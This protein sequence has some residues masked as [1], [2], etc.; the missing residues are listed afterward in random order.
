MSFVPFQRVTRFHHA[1]GRRGTFS[2]RV[3][4]S[5]PCTTA[6]H[7]TI[8]GISALDR[9]EGRTG[10][11]WGDAPT[12]YRPGSPAHSRIY[13]REVF[14]WR[15]AP[16][17]VRP[18]EGNGCWRASHPT[19]PRSAESAHPYP[20]GTSLNVGAGPDR[21]KRNFHLR[22]GQLFGLPHRSHG[23]PHDLDTEGA[24][25]ASRGR[26]YAKAGARGAETRRLSPGRYLKRAPR[27]P[28]GVWHGRAT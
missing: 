20:T 16:F 4:I 13:T 5:S 25:T 12:P 9:V 14:S 19:G 28:I 22:R 2:N 23:M 3:Q 17:Y 24:T 1:G 8:G 10:P 7:K 6:A 18:S 15:A 21:K 27:M 11:W 26:F